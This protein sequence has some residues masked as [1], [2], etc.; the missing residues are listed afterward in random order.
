MRKVFVPLLAVLLCAGV[1]ASYACADPVNTADVIGTLNISGYTMPGS[2]YVMQTY[3]PDGAVNGYSVYVG[4]TEITYNSWSQTKG[5]TLDITPSG[6]FLAYCIEPEWEGAGDFSLVA[7]AH[8]PSLEAMGDTKA[9]LLSE[10]WAENPTLWNGADSTPL[11]RAAFQLATWEIVWEALPTSPASYDV[12]IGGFYAN[13]NTSATD[14][15]WDKANWWLQGLN[16]NFEASNWTYSLY[17]LVNDG[18]QDFGIAASFKTGSEVPVPGTL[19]LCTI[20]LAFAAVVRRF[21]R[22]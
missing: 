3:F 7:A 6:K 17:G 8:A 11:D 14:D 16:G 5:D 22:S 9:K 20:G 13:G 21:R 19:L 15:A 2:P 10:L 4:R 12:N 18:K 1:L